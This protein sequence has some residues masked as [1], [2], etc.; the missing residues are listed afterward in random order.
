MKTIRLVLKKVDK[1]KYWYEYILCT[2]MY[3]SMYSL[4]NLF[5]NLNYRGNRSSLESPS[6]SLPMNGTSVNHPPVD[7]LV[8][9]PIGPA[10]FVSIAEDVPLSNGNM[11]K[12]KR[13]PKRMAD[14]T[15]CERP[16]KRP[17]KLTC[18]APILLNHNS[19][20]NESAVSH[21]NHMTPV[22]DGSFISQNG[23][24]S[25]FNG[26]S[27]CVGEGQDSIKGENVPKA[28]LHVN[29][30][31]VGVKFLENVVEQEKLLTLKKKKNVSV[32]KNNTSKVKQKATP[33]GKRKSQ[34]QKEGKEKLSEKKK[35]KPHQGGCER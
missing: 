15:V 4:I 10:H 31:E 11:N 18:T 14:G 16:A 35:A 9:S 6:V 22:I 24:S 20:N 19:N 23:Q 8:D 5:Y 28:D 21:D 33:T 26:F 30:R 27:E 29:N 17:P 34:T 13:L 25:G 12:R 1:R 2:F 32:E 7:P 3:I